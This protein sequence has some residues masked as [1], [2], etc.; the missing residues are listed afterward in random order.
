VP[1]QDRLRPHDAERTTPTTKPSTRQYP[2]ATIR[3][4]K[5]RPR[6]SALQHQQL[7]PQTKVLRNQ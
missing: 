2:K 3:I 6:I 7:L 4:A 1:P 5:P